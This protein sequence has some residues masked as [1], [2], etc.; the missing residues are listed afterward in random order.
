MRR[1]RTCLRWCTAA[2]LALVLAGCVPPG[3]LGRG[4]APDPSRYRVALVLIGPIGDAGWNASAYVGMQQVAKES[5]VDFAYSESVLLDES[6]AIIRDYA[7]RGYQLIIANQ[8]QYGDAML[9]VAQDY[10]KTQ[11]AVLTGRVKAP[12]L[13]SYD[14]VQREG[15]YL[16]GALA[17]LLSKTGRIG[18]VGGL[19]DPSIVRTVEGFKSG[20]RHA[21]PDIQILSAYT[22]SFTDIATA[23]EAALAQ[24]ARGADLVCHVANQA[25]LGVIAAAK[26]RRVFAIGTGNDQHP[27]APDTVLVTAFTD[28]G[29]LIRLVVRDAMSGRFGNQL[30]NAGLCEN[31]AGLTPFYTLD[32]QVP[33]EVKQTINTL[34]EEIKAGRLVVPEVSTKTT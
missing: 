30:V 17:A 10:P 22:N 12:N 31:V 8:Y 16:A 13:S 28:F 23:K 33:A 14:P 6:E 26:E 2:L 19:D 25:G 15:T 3:R 34:A 24:I 4:G 29:A 5:P 1:V 32:P 18:V 7:S 9:R 27:I 21:R 11:F 20:A